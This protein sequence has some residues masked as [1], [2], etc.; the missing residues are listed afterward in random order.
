M[1]RLNG[2]KCVYVKRGLLRWGME[3]G[4]EGEKDSGEGQ[5]VMRRI[6][7]LGKDGRRVVNGKV[8]R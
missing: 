5:G 8:R 3:V 6:R 1:S 4:R 2:K 7:A